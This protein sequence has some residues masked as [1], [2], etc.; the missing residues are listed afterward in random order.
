MATETEKQAPKARTNT[1]STPKIEKPAAP[2]QRIYVGPG[3]IELQ[4]YVVV[5]SEYPVHIAELV[6]K[7]PAIDKLFVPIANFTAVEQKIAKTGSLENKK[8][9]EVAEFLAKLRKGEA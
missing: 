9:Q 1:K 4:R 6:E 3:S 8:F 2:M 7:C 5:E